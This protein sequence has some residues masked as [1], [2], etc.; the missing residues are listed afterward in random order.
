[1]YLFDI[2]DVST[3]GSRLRFGHHLHIEYVER[4]ILRAP[5][6]PVSLVRDVL[7]KY[8][9]VYNIKNVSNNIYVYNI[10]NVKMKRL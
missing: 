2:R 7:H 1:M 4:R 3:E 9:K 6:V 5:A 8:P 10:K